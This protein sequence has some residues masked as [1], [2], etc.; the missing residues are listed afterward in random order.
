[1]VK[2]IK[3]FIFTADW[4]LGIRGL[5]RTDEVH[6]IQQDS[7]E[8][9]FSK[10]AEHNVDH[11]FHG[12]DMFDREN[13]N[14]REFTWLLEL[15]NKYG[16]TRD[17]FTMRAGNHDLYQKNPLF[18]ENSLVNVFVTMFNKQYDNINAYHFGEQRT[19]TDAEFVV[20][21]E[22]VDQN[23]VAS[24]IEQHNKSKYV[25]CG[26]HHEAFYKTIG[27]TTLLNSGALIRCS[28]S[29][30]APS[31]YLVKENEIFTI[32]L[33]DVSKSSFYVT[34]N[35][36]SKKITSI[37]DDAKQSMSE[38]GKLHCKSPLTGENITYEEFMKLNLDKEEFVAFNQELDTFSVK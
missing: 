16:I 2:D 3:S 24:I 19:N 26:D 20:L 17:N 13:F 18:L 5:S 9:I 8:L 32:P 30:P 4:H 14:I 36:L 15:C 6:K 11:I 35:S 28:S 21:H 37:T 1:M 34:K 33:L 23:N 22:Y 12:G 25:M 7:V 31:F 29:E 38:S 27:N 10:A